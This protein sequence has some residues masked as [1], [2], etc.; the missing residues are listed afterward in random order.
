MANKA[1][2]IHKRVFGCSICRRS[3]HGCGNNAAP[4]NGGYC[5]DS[6]NENVVIPARV[7]RMYAAIDAESA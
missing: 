7:E 3:V 6:C 2:D 4:V 1:R 5:C